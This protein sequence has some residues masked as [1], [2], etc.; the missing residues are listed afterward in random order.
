MERERTIFGPIWQLTFINGVGPRVGACGFG[1]HPRTVRGLALKGVWLAPVHSVAPGC[2]QLRSSAS[3][4]G[5][6]GPPLRYAVVPSGR[7]AIWKISDKSCIV[8]RNAPDRE[9]SK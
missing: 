8:R 9:V 7:L 1:A 3:L 5:Q 4:A 6:R 2:R